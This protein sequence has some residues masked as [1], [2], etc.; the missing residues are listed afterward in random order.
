MNKTQQQEDCIKCQL[1]CKALVFRIAPSKTSLEFY[2]ARGLK[3]HKDGSW[4]ADD[5]FVEVPHV[6]PHLT[7]NGCDIYENRPLACQAFDGKRN[8]ATK[9]K[10]LWNRRD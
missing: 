2:R 3:I 5:Y 9:E 1:C 6:C 10:C 8:V 4:L 7:N